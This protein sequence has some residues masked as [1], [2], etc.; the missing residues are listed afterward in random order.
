MI[1]RAGATAGKGPSRA[2][3]C[4]ATT[5]R[6]ATEVDRNSVRPDLIER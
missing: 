1:L 2:A 3:R 4:I 6:S 5:P